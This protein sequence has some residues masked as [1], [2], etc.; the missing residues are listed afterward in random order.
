MFAWEIKAK[1]FAALT[2][3]DLKM[4]IFLFLTCQFKNRMRRICCL[5][6]VITLF[7]N[8]SGLHAQVALAFNGVNNYVST[9]GSPVI[10][11][12]ARTVDAWI[13][14]TSS[15]TTQMVICDW[16]STTP[17]G[18]RFTLNTIAGKLR[19]EV[20]GVG[21]IGTTSVNTGQWTHV[22]AVY[23]PA[24]SSGPNVFLYING[25]LELSGNFTGYST[26][27][28]T[29]TVG[30]RI[31]VRTDGINFF[32]G[33]IDEVKVYNYARTQAQ[34]AADTMEVCVPQSGLVAYY[35]LNE[36]LPNAVN[37]NSTATDYS[38]NGNQ[39][40]LNSFTLSGTTSNWVTG[41]VRASSPTISVSPGANICS[42][43]TLTLSTNAT[44]GYTWSTGNSSS[45]LITLSPTVSGVYSI[46]ATNSLNCVSVSTLAVTVDTA[47]PSVT[48]VAAQSTVCPGMSTN[49]TASGAP[50][51]TWSGGI[52]NS[53]P[54]SPATTTAYT[55]TAGN[56]CGTSIT[57][58]TITVGTLPVTASANNSLV[59]QGYT[60][61]LSATSAMSGYTWQPGSQTG[62]TITVV[63]QAPTLYTVTASNGT[64]VSTQT[65]Q[66]N[67]LTTPS[68][69]L[70]NSIALICQGE[71]ATVSASGAGVGGT[72]TWAP[73]SLNSSSIVL[74]PSV[75][76]L[77]TVSG[78]N[79]LGCTAS[80]Q[81]PAVIQNTIMISI[82][83]AN[84]LVCQGDSLKLTG[85]GAG[86]Y[87][88]AN[89]ANTASV[90]V[91]PVSGYNTFSLAGMSS[92]NNCVSMQTIGI[93]VITP[94]VNYTS[95]LTIC[96]GASA[97]LSASGANT[98]TWN[99]IPTGTSGQ[100][101][102]SPQNSTT[103]T[104][105]AI[106]QSI[107]TQCRSTHLATVIVK[108]LPTLSVSS[109]NS[110][111]CKGG[112]VTL[113]A[114]GANTYTWNSGSTSGTV[115]ISP[116]TTSIYTV[117]GTD[118]NNC[119]GNLVVTQ[120]VSTCA[121]VSDWAKQDNFIKLFPNPTSGKLHIAFDFA[122]T[123]NVR[124][125]NE[126]G[127]LLL[128]VTTDAFEE[129]LDLSTFSA[130]VYYLTIF[131]AD[132]TSNLKVMVN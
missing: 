79:S 120:S 87:T 14:T 59:C 6:T 76:T 71:S 1:K 36:G 54:F 25:A 85:S 113:S 49:L 27:T 110:I 45:T 83:A 13:K 18:S 92:T 99:G 82:A 2:V 72:Y 77:Y 131:S 21:I 3:F 127:A 50:S 5:F 33:A 12:Q 123:K 116:T 81:I 70:S 42:G 37:T 47:V 94:S 102:V 104:L 34:I 90:Y 22:S 80:A 28:T 122:G 17:N 128:C 126:I 98:Y 93:A 68:I 52:T 48:V 64:C 130:G 9:G 8:R 38:G 73:G 39:G 132:K 53:Q 51:Y 114:S 115:L 31:G 56:G 29:T 10:N 69:T 111:I 23:D 100:Q 74:S 7:L 30:F 44:S 20:G 62:T 58:Y 101:L 95:S 32:N 43:N 63:P 15:V 91:K 84:T 11:N 119:I 121:S 112:S 117:T 118:A 86:T 40:T 78:T 67:T 129:E 66:V 35:R 106:T 124:I 16:G 125:Y 41:R 97:L 24:I 55:L 107:S 89:G 19:I 109:S 26:L 103:F 108:P 61:N 96:N 105:E 88:W 60:C 65:V 4:K 46:S 57:V 75:S